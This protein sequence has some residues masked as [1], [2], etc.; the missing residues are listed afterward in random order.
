MKR[1]LRYLRG[2]SNFGLQYY[3]NQDDLTLYGFVDADYSGDLDDRKSRTGYVYKLS[4]GPISWTSG[5]QGVT[6]DSRTEAEFVALAEACKEGIWLR[7]LLLSLVI[8]KI[9]RHQYIVTINLLSA[10]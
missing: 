9:F 3:G 8:L 2:T 5:R 1:I 4:H 10:S 6:A 7:R